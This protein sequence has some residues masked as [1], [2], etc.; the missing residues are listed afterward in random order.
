MTPEKPQKSEERLTINRSYDI[1]LDQNE[2]LVNSPMNKSKLIRALLDNH[3][4]GMDSMVIQNLQ[5]EIDL[6]YSLSKKDKEIHDDTVRE[7]ME[8][9][10]SQKA[11]IVALGG[12]E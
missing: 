4:N 9:I 12:E 10:E 11:A 3:I 2:W 6:L 8:K 1:Y 7:L 5:D